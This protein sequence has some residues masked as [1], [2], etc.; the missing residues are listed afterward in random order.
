[1]ISSKS[2]IKPSIL[3]FRVAVVVV[4]HVSTQV[5]FVHPCT[6][7]DGSFSLFCIDS[8]WVT[9]VTES[10]KTHDSCEDGPVWPDMIL[11]PFFATVVKWKQAQK[12]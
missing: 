10:R 2:M 7:L 11:W 3:E 12:L 8:P 6:I 5:W 9:T 1:M 4:L